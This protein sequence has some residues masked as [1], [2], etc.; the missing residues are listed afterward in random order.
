MDHKIVKQQRPARRVAPPTPE[1]HPHR[2]LGSFLLHP[3]EVLKGYRRGDVSPDLFAGLTVAAVAIPQAIAYAAIAELPPHYGLYTAAVAAV[4]GSLFGSSRHLATGPVNAIS[5]LVLPVLLSLGAPGSAQFMLGASLLAVMAGL[6]SISLA[7]MHF[8]ALVTLASRSVLLGF[9]AGAAVHIAVGQSRHLLGVELPRSPELMVT[10]ALLATRVSR[11]HLDSLLMGLGTLAALLGLKQLGQRV[12]AALLAVTGAVV[13]VHLLGLEARGM[14]VVGEIPRSLPMPTWITVGALPDLG[15]IRTLVVDSLAV[16]ALGLVEAVASAQSLA[17][18]SHDRLDSNQ[19]FFGQG[20]ANLLS[21]LLSGYP[22]SGSFT[23]SALAQQAG[24]RTPMTGVFTGLTIL[25]GM[26]LLAPYARAVPKAAIA[27][28]LLVVAWG[29]IDR[30]GIRRVLRSS[31]AE[32]AIM[33]VTF[34]STLFLPLDFAVLSGIVFSLAFFVIRSSLPRVY[35]VVPDPTFRFFMHDT[36]APVCPQLGIMNIRGPLFFGAVYHIE[37]ELR[38]NHE[39]HPGQNLL[40]LKLNGVDICDLSGIEMLEATVQTYRE[41]GGDVFLIH[42]SR[43][44]MKI[45]LD[46]D[47]LDETLGPDNVMELEDAIDYLFENA[48]DHHVCVYEC[49][50]RVFAECH[51]L[52]KHSYDDLPSA[53]ESMHGHSRQVPPETFHELTAIPDA[54]LLDMREPGEF[55][56]VHLPGARL[57]PLRLLGDRIDQLPRDVPLLLTCRSGRRT[58]RALAMLEERGFTRLYGLWGGL[59]AW[60]SEGLPLAHEDED[61]EVEVWPDGGTPAVMDEDDN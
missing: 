54:L 34:L 61:A 32:T 17:R 3:L 9:T 6:L 28:V 58:T 24:G 57:L 15:M 51:A 53:A 46:S 23:R 14:Q 1:G 43:P 37:E 49:E 27:G 26:L 52:Q 47:F 42:P 22:C 11:V 36:K 39:H 33:T 35:P 38:H 45:L 5:L 10:V 40:M 44:V 19:E 18:V 59:H 31:R 21:G 56:R 41:R 4:V 12:P 16:A 13:A 30:E 20:M 25:A 48:L 50:H 2:G 7:L 8:G 29:M 60:R 55:H